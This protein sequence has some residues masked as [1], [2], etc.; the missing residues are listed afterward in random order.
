[1][2]FERPSA[3][4]AFSLALCAFLLLG[5]SPVYSQEDNWCDRAGG[6]PAGSSFAVDFSAAHGGVRFFGVQSKYSIADQALALALNDPSA[7]TTGELAALQSYSVSLGGV[8]IAPAGAASLS[9]AQ[10]ISFGDL[11]LVRPGTG[12]VT[13]PSNVSTV[14]IDLRDLPAVDGLRA[15]L[16][17]SVAQVLKKPVPRPIR[18]VREHV[19]MTDEVWAEVNAYSNRIIELSQSDIPGSAQGG[20]TITLALLTGLRTAPEA[21]QFAGTLR[22]ARAA[23]LVGQDIS[24]SLAESRWRG[25]GSSAQTG[26][27]LVYR[28]EDLFDPGPPHPSRWPDVIPADVRA[29]NPSLDDLSRI[30]RGLGS[31]SQVSG[32]ATRPQL[33]PMAPYRDI[34]PATNR[35]GDARAQ[36]VIYHGALR[37]FFPYFPVV[38]DSIDPRLLETLAS[39]P[40]GPTV[41]AVTSWKA[42]KRLGEAVADGHV[43]VRNFNLA[44]PLFPG[45]LGL[46]LEQVGSEPVVRYSPTPALLKGDTITAIGG[47]SAADWFADEYLRAPA[48]TDG[49]KFHVAYQRG[50]IWQMS[51]PLDFGL[52]AP[53]GSTRTVTVPFQPYPLTTNIDYNLRPEGFLTDLGAPGIYFIN[54]SF[55]VIGSDQAR[56][57]AAVDAAINGHASG[58]ILDMRGSKALG[59]QRLLNNR[60]ICTHFSSMTFNVPVLSGPDSKSVRSSH[61]EVDPLNP[62]CGPMVL[63]VS[64]QTLSNAEDFSAQLVGAH[65]VTVVG[66]QS[67]GTNG[68]ITG[69]QLPGALANSFTGMEVRN[70]NGSVFHGVGIV[71]DVNVSYTA[72]DI[73][74]GRDRDLEAAIQVLQ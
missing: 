25:V 33:Q 22:L 10:V 57:D 59:D 40:S 63:L 30:L 4:L 65:R 39:L 48:A 62:Y 9:P 3:F 14:V 13:I 5:S 49:F 50:G 46:N 66:R 34:Q 11:A 47:M 69:I 70:V 18:M 27:G 67:A 52:R 35:L 23:W 17:A 71:P 8:C 7:L 68:N 12:S 31:P 61:Y 58:M 16:D 55:A 43:F 44:S 60:L 74:D 54:L 19:G 21:A 28:F 53:D 32:A 20:Q 2:K 42:L 15:A 73:A 37:L 1:M 56:F 24:S 45:G 51:A 38:G 36:L 6:G 64:A 72:Q 41:D 26:S 29:D